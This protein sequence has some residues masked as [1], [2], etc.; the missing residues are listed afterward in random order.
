MYEKN[1]MIVRLLF[2]V[3]AILAVLLPAATAA[4]TPVQSAPVVTVYSQGVACVV[5]SITLSLTAGTTD[6]E[7][8]VP[9]GLIP[10]SVLLTTDGTVL[11]QAF[12]YTSA[13]SIGNSAIGKQVEIVTADGLYRGVLLV[14][15][16]DAV[17]IRDNAG[18]IRTIVHPEQIVLPNDQVSSLAP[19][20]TVKIQSDHAGDV[21]AELSYLTRNVN[22]SG[23]YVGI[24]NADQKTMS[25]LGQITLANNSG[26]DFKSATMRFIAGDVNQTSNSQLM[27]RAAPMAALE[28]ADASVQGAFEYHLYTLP[29]TLDLVNGDS[30]I[31]PY[32]A[33]N[34]VSIDKTYVYDGASAPGVQVNL[35]FAN[36][37]DNELGMPLPAG[38]VR[39][40]GDVDGARLF[41]GDDAI[42]HT[43]SDET[44]TLS[45]GSAFDIVG[46]RTLVSRE[47]IGTSTYRESYLITLR[48]HKDSAVKVDVL[49]HP[50]GTWNVTTSSSE[51]ETVN[52]NTIRFVTNVPAGGKSE[53]S[54]TVEYKY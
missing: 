38:T 19:T 31:V 43:A 49:E 29:G 34:G 14:A 27:M 15:G 7:L 22:W 2:V 36:S 48:N 9:A 5:E 20:L 3:V 54:Y 25:L 10:E 47:K 44:V 40:F 37:K 45:V 6:V 33:A 18:A 21:P 32:V 13:G 39:M 26:Y 50:S 52:A 53:V 1:I 46:E 23:T 4:A 12:H 30:L 51:F 42:G 11:S 16:T 41:L 17:T 8:P 35:S 24:L 28:A